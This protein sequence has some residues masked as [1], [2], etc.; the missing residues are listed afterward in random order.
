MCSLVGLPCASLE[1]PFR[2]GRRRAG[3]AASKLRFLLRTGHD[4]VNFV[5][6][7]SQLAQLNDFALVIGRSSSHEQEKRSLA[8]RDDGFGPLGWGF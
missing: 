8:C 3:G 1:L 4:G 2:V 6:M 7:G 5:S